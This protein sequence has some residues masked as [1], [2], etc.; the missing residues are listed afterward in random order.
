MPE[1]T[2]LYKICWG[3]DT[4]AWGR[5][6]YVHCMRC[7]QPCNDHAIDSDDGDISEAMP[8][9]VR[10][11]QDEK[12]HHADDLLPGAVRYDDDGEEVP[13]P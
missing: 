12:R 11:I 1:L 4:S 2:D 13:A 6:F 5:G 9:I 10:L 8:A 3:D 7:D